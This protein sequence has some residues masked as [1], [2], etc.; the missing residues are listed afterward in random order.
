MKAKQT[1][2]YVIFTKPV[3]LV[4]IHNI[5]RKRWGWRQK[6]KRTG[7]VF[8]SWGWE[9][10]ELRTLHS[11]S[12]FYLGAMSSGTGPAV[13]TAIPSCCAFILAQPFPKSSSP[14]NSTDPITHPIS[15]FYMCSQKAGTTVPHLG[16]T[17]WVKHSIL[18]RN[19]YASAPVEEL[20]IQCC[21]KSWLPILLQTLYK[22]C[23]F[24]WTLSNYRYILRK[25]RKRPD[26]IRKR[27]NERWE[28]GQEVKDLKRG[29]D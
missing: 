11:R 18:H 27:R 12:N 8:L 1:R 14:Q 23:N 2:C 5:D 21:N 25:S 29:A 7:S 20:F 9:R 22:L 28:V 26:I 10:S 4:N 15:P 19:I 13:D 3:E 16:S 17:R 6:A 24:K